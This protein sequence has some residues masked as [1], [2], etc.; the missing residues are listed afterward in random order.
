MVPRTA[1]RHGTAAVAGAAESTVS[2]SATPGHRGLLSAAGDR[3]RYAGEASS[4]GQSA[5]SLP[6]QRRVG[7]TA[8][9]SCAPMTSPS[10]R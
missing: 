5:A 1:D 8:Q 9:H 2:R 6:R 10:P 4:L 7:G 3:A